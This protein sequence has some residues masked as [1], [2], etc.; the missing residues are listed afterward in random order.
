MQPKKIKNWRTTN[1]KKKNIRNIKV[2]ETKVY[3]INFNK[4]I[5]VKRV[6]EGKNWI[7]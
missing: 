7:N 2:Y 4:D 5:Q 3:W 6:F 1:K